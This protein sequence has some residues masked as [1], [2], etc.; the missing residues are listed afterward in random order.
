MDT[1]ETEKLNETDGAIQTYIVQPVMLP[2][3]PA[4]GN[5]LAETFNIDAV[6]IVANGQLNVIMSFMIP[7]NVNPSQVSIKQ[8]YSSTEPSS[9]SFY[10]SYA[11]NLTSEIV[12]VNCKFR[13]S[14]TDARGRA[15]SLG[16]VLSISTMVVC[17]VGPKTS[18]GVMTS[19]R[20]TEV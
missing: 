12:Q 19:V 13:A 14:T 11:S 7:A 9:L 1:N 6:Y 10:A 16:S 18:R 5:S 4:S 20:T 2:I 3:L 15:I 8:Y 17:T